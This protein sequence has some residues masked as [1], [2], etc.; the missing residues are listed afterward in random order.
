MK[1]LKKIIFNHEHV[2]QF[3]YLKTTQNNLSSCI[4]EF[5]LSE[6]INYIQIQIKGPFFGISADEVTN[7]LNWKQLGIVVRYIN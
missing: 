6:I 1:K 7:A 3:T 5:V 2:M 4:K